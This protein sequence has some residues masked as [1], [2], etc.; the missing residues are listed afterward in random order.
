MTR[1]NVVV[2]GQTEEAFAKQ[3]LAPHLSG[4]EV[5]LHPIVVSAA[6]TRQSQG[7]RG[8]G[9]SFGK[10]L[11]TIRDAL[12]KDRSAYCTT[13]FDYYGLPADYPGLDSEDCPPSTR[14][15]DRIEFLEKRLVQEIGDTHR[16]LPY[17]Q[18]HEFEALLFADVNVIDRA[19]GLQSAAESRLD[20]L[21]S[22]ID[23]FETPEWIDDGEETA[24]SKRLQDLFPRYDKVVHG[25]M[26]PH[27]IGLNRIRA[28][29]PH[30]NSWINQLESLE[31]LSS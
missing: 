2:E 24:P 6:R 12:K 7:H 30:F 5:Y 26:I 17:L 10:A 13:M 8:G 23:H 1:I 21:Q 29:C 31:P 25:E 28:E 11:R 14:L 4:H 3:V 20:D 15:Y 9:G 18:D 22:I 16:F 27:D 19:P